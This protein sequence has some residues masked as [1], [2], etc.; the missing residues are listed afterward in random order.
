MG[1]LG[2]P[3]MQ[4]EGNGSYASHL[5]WYQDRIDNVD[6]QGG[7]LPRPWV[8]SVS[9]WWYRGLMLAWALWLAGSLVRWLPW[10]WGSFSAGGLWRHLITPRPRPLAPLP[11]RPTR[12]GSGSGPLPASPAVTHASSVQTSGIQPQTGMAHTSS[13]SEAIFANSG[14]SL[15]GEPPLA[16]P[17]PP[18]PGDTLPHAQVVPAEKAET[19]SVS[20]SPRPLAPRSRVPPPPVRGGPR[21]E[22]LE[23]MPEDDDEV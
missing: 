5:V 2:Q 17:R 4:I 22:P 21:R 20:V 19:T 16:G 15:V 8:L 3:D 13:V 10:A 7:L 1:L 14:N 23:L 11:P 18:G 6:G 9:M 12:S